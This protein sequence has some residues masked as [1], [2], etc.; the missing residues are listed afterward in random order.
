MVSSKASNSTKTTSSTTTS[1]TSN[2]IFIAR[3]DG[4]KKAK[5]RFETAKKSLPFHLKYII[6]GYILDRF[7]DNEFDKYT[8]DDWYKFGVSI[9]KRSEFCHSMHVK[10]EPIIQLKANA[11]QAE[12]GLQKYDR[13]V[14]I[15]D[16]SPMVWNDGTGCLKH[17][18]T[19]H[20]TKYESLGCH[21]YHNDI[22]AINLVMK[23]ADNFF[24]EWLP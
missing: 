8:C 12:I 7:N 3:D 24:A 11:T 21:A 9:Q 5:N 14:E 16:K 23:F 10:G 6:E 17:N 18:D 1:A 13:I 15:L 20:N 4:I 19:Q 22:P 2:V